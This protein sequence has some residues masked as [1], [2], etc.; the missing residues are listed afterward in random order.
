M[1]S[2]SPGPR[3]RIGASPEPVRS[4]APIPFESGRTRMRAP[5]GRVPH[6][7]VEATDVEPA[8]A[9]GSFT[10]GDLRLPPKIFDKL[11]LAVRQFGLELEPTEVGV[12]DDTVR[13]HRIRANA[14]S[15]ALLYLD[16]SRDDARNP[17]W[18]VSS[19]CV[20]IC[21]AAGVDGFDKPVIIFVSPTEGIVWHWRTEAEECGKV[22][23]ARE[24][25]FARIGSVVEWEQSTDRV[26]R[27]AREWTAILRSGAARPAPFNEV[28]GFVVASEV[29]PPVKTN[30]TG[31]QIQRFYAFVASPNDLEDERKL[32]RQSFDQFN[33]NI[34]SL[35]GIE[36]HLL[37]WEAFSNA[38]Q[39]EPEDLIIKQVLEQYKE[40]LVLVICLFANRYGTPTPTHASGTEAEFEWAI[41]AQKQNTWPEVKLFFKESPFDVTTR[42]T[43]EVEQYTRVR[44]FRDR[45]YRE[46]ANLF[47]AF[48]TDTYRDIVENDVES[49]LFKQIPRL[50]SSS[51]R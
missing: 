16:E 32:L 15:V 24:I 48:K 36:Y 33:R 18:Y 11:Q 14:A 9:P 12:D 27:F 41:N 4:A 30:P 42:P 23:I 51:S 49:W 3:P 28:D 13:F 17:K 1:S 25:K 45:I 2:T 50:A 43:E 44:Q 5:F 35:Y 47:K 8:T 38:G 6:P 19:L 40:A 37:E 34:G 29:P 39:G 21:A 31:I 7:S 22:G 46:K 26:T 10:T 20:R